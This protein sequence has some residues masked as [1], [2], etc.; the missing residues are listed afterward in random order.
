VVAS[1]IRASSVRTSHEGIV[2]PTCDGILAG[3]HFDE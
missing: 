3:L 1:V 2:R